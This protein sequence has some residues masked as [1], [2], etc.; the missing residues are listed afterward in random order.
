MDD[1][2]D[3]MAKKRYR[4]F[5]ILDWNENYF[6]MISRRSLLGAR[7]KKLIL[8]DHNELT[9]A[10][11][12]MEEAEIIEIIDHHRIGSIEDNGTGIF[13]QSAVRLY[14]NDHLSNVPRVRCGTRQED[15]RVYCAPQSCPIR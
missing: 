4:D 2:R 11:D 8:V 9:Q 6:G 3:T 1:I 7:K 13:P 12:G 10:V 5:P 15:C 14:G